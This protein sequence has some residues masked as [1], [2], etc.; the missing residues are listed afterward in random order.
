MLKYISLL[1]KTWTPL[2][3]EILASNLT[4]ANRSILKGQIQLVTKVQRTLAWNEIN[5]YSIK[6]GRVNWSAA[7]TWVNHDEQDLAKM[8]V[9]VGETELNVRFVAVAGH[10]F[11]I[12]TRPSPKPLA[13]LVAT[14]VLSFQSFESELNKPG[15]LKV[16]PLIL[17]EIA[18]ALSGDW[19]ILTPEK[20]YGV[21]LP[22]GDFLV[23]ATNDSDGYLMLLDP[24]TTKL[25]YATHDGSTPVAVQDL[26]A[27]FYQD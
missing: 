8:R 23:V 15:K 2:E 18:S 3:L 26:S 20:V 10:L 17:A 9:R 12:I 1:W 7:P 6:Q 19:G 21:H 5:L 22:E 25:Y 14:D 16:S 13:F 27:C 4:E 11:S 24:P